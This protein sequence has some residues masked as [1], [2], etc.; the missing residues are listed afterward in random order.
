MKEKIF[1]SLIIL[2]LVLTTVSALD[3][4]RTQKL[5]FGHVLYMS[6]ITTT[7]ENVAPGSQAVISFNIEN[8]ALDNLSDIRVSLDLPAEI[9]TYYDITTKK[10]AR[11]SS[12]E[13]INLQFNIIVLPNTEEGVYKVPVNLDYLNSIGDERNEDENISIIVKSTPKLYAEIK[14][15]EVYDGNSLGNVAVRIVNN[16]VGNIKFLT[17]RLE[18]SKDYEIISSNSEYVGDL[19]SD[20]YSDVTFKIRAKSDDE[21]ITLPLVLTYKDSLNQDYNEKINVTLKMLSAS[22]LGIKKSKAGWV[23]LIIIIG[24]GGYIYYRKYKAKNLVKDKRASFSFSKDLI[25]K[26]K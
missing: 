7:P 4:D 25:F 14:S 24:V 15:T 2:V 20:D 17:V 6:N 26:K 18:N 19:N 10:I 1:V 3:A 11:M 16:N 5:R 23:L 9:A 21:N 22:E 12:G 8:T 13:N